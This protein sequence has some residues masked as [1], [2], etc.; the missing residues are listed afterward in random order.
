MADCSTFDTLVVDWLYDELDPAEAARITRHVDGCAACWQ[1]AESLVQVRALFRAMPEEEPPGAI[2][3][4]VLREAAA[5]A[6]SRQ[7]RGLGQLVSAW[8]TG[9][10]GRA[11]AHPAAAAVAS[12]VLVA[13]VAGALFARGQLEMAAPRHESAAI[14]RD[15]VRG[16]KGAVAGFTG[17][18]E[19][20][21]AAPDPE[22]V[23]PSEMAEAGLG[24]DASRDR[25][26]PSGTRAQLSEGKRGV[27]RARRALPARPAPRADREVERGLAARAGDAEE[28]TA[29]LAQDVVGEARQ[30]R[31]ADRDGEGYVGGSGAAGNETFVQ[32][33]AAAAPSQKAAET[34][35]GLD[36]SEP[37]PPATETANPK[38]RTESWA[39]SQHAELRAALRD[40][41]CTRALGIA[42]DIQAREPGYY[43]S[44]L[45]SSK[46]LAAC[47][48]TGRKA[49]N[50]SS[51]PQERTK[52]AADT[53]KSAGSTS[54]E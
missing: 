50:R 46:E 49:A 21:A 4:R 6:A 43:R 19:S 28:Q 11:F 35:A 51:K 5:H 23:Q 29:L 10:F 14:H 26:R 1:T 16:E 54:A 9:A 18:S 37:A 45:A 42:S 3:A 48:A 13:G 30:E 8:I 22:A 15:D 53:A 36:E 12:L 47:R 52:R 44:Q 25:D 32:A 33:P 24:D 31:P 38:L 2:S 39:E 20:R 40:Q 27:E 41:Q 7:E 17:G 34:S